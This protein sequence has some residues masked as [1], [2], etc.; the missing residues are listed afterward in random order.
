MTE[1]INSSANIEWKQDAAS[2][3]KNTRA[4]RRIDEKKINLSNK[5]NDKLDIGLSKF[6]ASSGNLKKIRKKIKDVFDEDDEEENDFVFTHNP[7]LFNNDYDSKQ[8]SLLESLNSD[9]KQQLVSQQT[10]KNQTLQRSSKKMGDILNAQKELKDSG[11]K[12]I[13][14]K[15]INDTMINIAADEKA[16]DVTIQKQIKKT[17]NI[18]IK[19]S[20][21]HQEIKDFVKGLDKVQK[22][23]DTFLEN[24][25]KPFEKLNSDDFV[26]IGKEKNNQKVAQTI[27]EKTGRDKKNKNN[28]SIK[29]KDTKAKKVQNKAPKV[30]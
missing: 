5:K 22:S 10:I 29:E 14:K 13:D 1:D 24:D 26:N 4:T 2:V 17:A 19:D 3:S 16:F 9:E 8:S 23:Q 18:K 15:L 11:I 30:R 27:I 28:E 20:Y 6:G 7:L 25:K 12:K 21:S